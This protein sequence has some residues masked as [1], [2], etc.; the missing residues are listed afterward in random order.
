MQHHWQHA[1]FLQTG[2]APCHAACY[3][4]GTVL[5]SH[6]CT[7]QEE[8]LAGQEQQEAAAAAGAA[9][10]SSLGVGSPLAGEASGH[11]GRGAA[12]RAVQAT[13]AYAA[14]YIAL[15]YAMQPSKQVYVDS[16]LAVQR[17]LP[18]PHLRAGPLL[19][20]H[21]DGEGTPD[22]RWV[23]CWFGLGPD[24]L[25]AVRP[26][27]AHAAS[28]GHGGPL[29]KAPPPIRYDLADVSD[30]RLAA[31]PS[32]P[33]GAAFWLGLCSNP[34]WARRRA[35][36]TAGRGRSRAGRCRGRPRTSA[37][38]LTSPPAGPPRCLQGRIPGGSRPGRRGGVGGRA[39]AAVAPAARRV[40]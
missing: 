11:G 31:D 12:E 4:L 25:A 21:P 13:F 5:Y 16:L 17:L 33:R 40:H 26:P 6:A 1:P 36:K 29:A 19:A 7:L 35:A 38:P 34:R 2:V 32:L 37:S 39:A 28:G 15:A 24:G 10:S 30:A 27:A 23:Q 18:L 8:L 14:Q 20:V 9:R 22:E 3:N